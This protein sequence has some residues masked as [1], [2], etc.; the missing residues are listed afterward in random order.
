MTEVEPEVVLAANRWASNAEL[1][2]DV[3]KLGYLN[4]DWLTLDPTYGRGI[5]W[6][7]WRPNTLITHN[8][9][10]DGVDF[11]KLPH[12]D[13]TFQAIAF[14]PTYVS[15]G[16]R[17]TTGIP[18]FHAQYGMAD[19]ATT[20]AGVQAEINDGLDEMIR[21]LGSRGS[22]LVKCQDYISSG[23]FWPGTHYT[24][25]HALALGC[26]LIDRLEHIGS[27]RRQPTR[28]RKDGTPV[29]Q[30]HSRRNL[31]TLLVFRGPK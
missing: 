28:T 10:Q 21:V 15:V 17:K 23:Q 9:D 16:G 13:S 18:E 11:R 2:E 5:W 19:A 31:S 4:A 24:L 29:V 30:Q 20:P 12:A 14:D 27:P 26:E 6:K 25:S 7:K 1:I 8:R 22:L 3:A